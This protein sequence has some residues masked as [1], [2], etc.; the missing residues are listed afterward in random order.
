MIR[1]FCHPLGAIFGVALLSIC[2]MSGCEA[3]SESTGA[4]IKRGNELSS[5]GDLDAGI[6]A[7]N[8]AIRLE[9][10]SSKAYRCRA[11]AYCQKHDYD[12]AI[13]DDTT[14]IRL[15]PTS[16]SYVGRAYD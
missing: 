1:D 4:A 14:A 6:A 3:D 12:K 11:C 9:P 7:Y 15:D 10:N 16:D 5:R 13:A 8:K 2:F